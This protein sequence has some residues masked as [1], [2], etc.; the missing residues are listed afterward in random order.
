MDWFPNRLRAVRVRR[1]FVESAACAVWQFYDWKKRLREGE[2]AK[3]VEVA[4]SAR[5]GLAIASGT[6]QGD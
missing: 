2:A 3:F 4:V 5:R 1:R 6:D